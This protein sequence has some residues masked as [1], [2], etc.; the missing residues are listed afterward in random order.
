MYPHLGYPDLG[1]QQMI[2][3]IG[4]AAVLLAKIPGLAWFHRWPKKPADG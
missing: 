1:R 4:Y 2:A 3:T